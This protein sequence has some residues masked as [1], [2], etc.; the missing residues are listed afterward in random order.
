MDLYQQIFFTTIAIAFAML[1]FILY[2]YNRELKSNLFFAIFLLFYALNIF[3][4]F[5]EFI[6]HQYGNSLIFLSLHRFVLPWNTIFLL[7]FTY[8]LFNYRIPVQFWIVSAG[9][10][11]TGFFGLFNP[12][13]N[14]IYIQIFILG[15][16]I[17]ITRVFIKA[18]KN[19]KEGAKITA[20]G[21]L[22][23]FLFSMY[24][25]LLDL[26]LMNPVYNIR[27]GYPFG[28]GILIIFISIYLARNYA[29]ANKRILA[30]EVKARE[31]E[32][33]QRVLV[34]E[35]AR[36]SKELEEA[37]H[38][39]LAMLPS[40]VPDVPGMDIQYD[41]RTATEVGGD[42]YDYHISEDGVLSLAIGD[43]TGHGM[44][45]GLMVSIIKS[46][47][48]THV[49]EMDI[50]NF[51]TKVSGTLRQ[52]NLKKLYM[53]LMLLKIKD[54]KIIFSSA[55]MPPLYL[56]RKKTD[57]VEEFIIKG[58][59]LG[60]VDTFAYDIKEISL[61]PGDVFL[62]MSDGFPELFNENN[63]MLDDI[64]VKEIFKD[65]A[66][67]PVRD[68]LNYLFNAGDEWRKEKDL[69]DDVTFVIG[70]LL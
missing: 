31:M 6:S 37:R 11:I 43:A 54:D 18:I 21:F 61:A 64:R 68:I 65:A 17:E 14:L 49:G 23:L 33:N 27:N 46:L 59:P 15:G 30:Q 34:A 45:A 3:F 48:I 60:A 29:N 4:D 63:E 36:K 9:L 22:L 12:V 50:L 41:M 44:K 2:I 1:H 40:T 52:M 57:T 25:L 20:S 39:Q 56:Y 58:M 19:K 42:Y 55:G 62:M 28:F 7:L 26:N 51:L 32:I 5:Q 10:I 16:A 69:H 35:D 24:D 38:L 67:L 13:E 8:F 66:N 70:K 53:S 47:F